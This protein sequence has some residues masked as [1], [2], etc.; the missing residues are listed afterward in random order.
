M[1]SAVPTTIEWEMA[2]PS[3]QLDHTKRAVA[4]KE[5][6][7]ATLTVWDDPTIHA[8][9]T[10]AFD[11]TPSTVTGKPAGSVVTVTVDVGKPGL[12]A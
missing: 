10:G 12:L 11:V 5:I 8:V 6:G 3:L 2:P 1:A 7:D 4:P 9:A